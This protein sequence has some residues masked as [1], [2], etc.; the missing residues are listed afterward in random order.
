MD[1]DFTQIYL[2]SDAVYAL[3]VAYLRKLKSF[4]NRQSLK[5]GFFKKKFDWDNYECTLVFMISATRK[6]DVL[7]IKG[8]SYHKKGRAVEFAIY[9]PYRDF[10]DEHQKFIYVARYL[11]QAAIEILH[12]YK[13]DS[14]QLAGLYDEFILQLA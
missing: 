7:E 11:R 1:I 9:I 2:E 14:T 6:S 10:S 12:K 3:P 8:P 4:L 5:I 13:T